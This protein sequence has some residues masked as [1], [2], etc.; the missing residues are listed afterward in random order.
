VTYFGGPLTAAL[1][2]A[3]EGLGALA[4]G[5][6]PLRIE[7][8][9]RKLYDAANYSG[10]AGIFT[11]AFSAI[12]MALWDIKGKALGAPLWRLLGGA[13]ERVP[14]Y[15]SGALMR[16]LSLERATASARRLVETGFREVKMQL[17]LPGET[18][19]ELEVARARAIR[20]AVGAETR[21]MV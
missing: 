10:P 19:P 20:D 4:I 14:T 18:S 21:L 15:A 11:L 12:D 1:R 2:A 13:R 8:I 3:V 17:A 7:A 5:E 6:D 9:G 16:G